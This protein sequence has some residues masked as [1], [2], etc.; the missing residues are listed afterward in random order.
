[1]A[2]GLESEEAAMVESPL[3]TVPEAARFFRVDQRTIRR[4]C[5]SGQLPAVRV[6]GRGPWRIDT[7]GE[8]LDTSAKGARPVNGRLR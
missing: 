2:G 8:L 1:M 3:M 6:G 7:T 5:A 4:Y